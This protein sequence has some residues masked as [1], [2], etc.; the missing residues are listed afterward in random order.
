MPKPKRQHYEWVPRLNLYRKRIKDVDGKYVPIYA[1]TERELDA[2]LEEART[3]I[4]AGLAAKADPTVRS[5]SLIHISEPT[6][7]Y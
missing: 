3:V 2:K 6:R 7:P 4:S 5:L 1:K